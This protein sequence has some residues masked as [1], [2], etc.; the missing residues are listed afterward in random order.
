[1]GVK[2][3]RDLIGALNILIIGKQGRLI[4]NQALPTHIVYKYPAKVAGSS[5]GHLASS[6]RK[7]EAAGL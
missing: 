4:P 2:G 3:P 6:S 5:S 7:R 1:C